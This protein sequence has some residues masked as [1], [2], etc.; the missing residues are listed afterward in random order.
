MHP[1]ELYL[2][3][4]VLNDAIPN[5]VR[6]D[7]HELGQSKLVRLVIAASRSSSSIKT[8]TRR[9]MRLDELYLMYSVLNDAIPNIVRLDA[10]ELGQSKLVRLVI[11]A[12]HSSSSIKT[13][14]R[15][16]MRL[17]EL[18][19]MY[20]VL[21]DAIPN[22]VRLD[23]HELGQSK[24]VRLVIAASHSSS[25]IKTGT[26][27]IMRLDE[28]YLMYS[29]LNDAIPN[30]VRLDAHELGQSK[31]VCLVIAASRSSSSVKTG[32][33]RIMRPDELYLMYSVLNDAL[34]NIARLHGLSVLC[35]LYT[36]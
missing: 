17:D 27:R 20:S 28:L 32:R 22:I 13:G 6:L 5:I 16:I 25:S 14:T 8:G 21:N 7:A 26:R 23:A 18:Y 33:R 31:L 4:S 15:Q 3:Y 36:G 12:S 11:A 29:V 24:L 9:I 19:L 34:P 1:D 10:H 2:M 35:H 30:I